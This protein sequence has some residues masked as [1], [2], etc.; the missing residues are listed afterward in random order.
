M[1]T[2]VLRYFVEVARNNSI[3]KAAQ[4]LH[5]TQPTLSRQLKELER[6]VGQKL[7]LRSNYH[8]KLT[9]Q[10][11]TLYKRAIDI[12][13]LID[14]T[15]LEFSSMNDFDGGEINIGC[16]ESEGISLVANVAK[17][18]QSTYHNIRFNL[19]SGNFQ[20]LTSYLNNGLL[21]FAVVVQNMDTSL[22]NSL[23][24]PY[25]DK[26]GILM[27]KDDPLAS[28]TNISFDD[29]C[30]LP[31]IISR[32]GFTD[33]MPNEIKN[34]QEKLNIVATYDLIYN[35]SIF[36]REGL[37]YAFSFDKLINTDGDS[38]LCFKPINPPILS[39]MR[40]IWAKPDQLSKAAS[41][42]LEEFTKQIV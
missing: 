22:Y 42:F 24:L 37:G 14:K 20:S 13:A 39:P 28:K 15:I 1:E 2:R 34:M 21:D 25:E 18:L 40:L 8:I 36:V 31:L 23:P 12:L 33:E 10:G 27:R 6:E 35:A 3:T 38:S 5:I 32:Q 9:P 4:K 26:W 30:S 19:H 16:A 11:Q 29:F 17:K 7:F 41:I